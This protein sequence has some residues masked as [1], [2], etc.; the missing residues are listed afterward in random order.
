MN[1]EL[2]IPVAP[3]L[4]VYINYFP[5]LFPQCDKGRVTIIIPHH[6]DEE[7]GTETLSHLPRIPQGVRD[8]AIVRL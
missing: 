5:E 6:T 2:R 3:D 8:R 7:T 1:K 4:A